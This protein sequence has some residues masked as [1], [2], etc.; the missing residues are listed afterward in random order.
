[1]LYWFY[2]HKIFLK[3]HE[4]IYL[5]SETGIGALVYSYVNLDHEMQQICLKNASTEMIGTQNNVT[6]T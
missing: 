3:C 6:Y 1:M 4:Y 5:T 2:Q